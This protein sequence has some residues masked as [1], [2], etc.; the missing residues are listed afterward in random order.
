MLFL[1]YVEWTGLRVYDGMRHVCM[2]HHIC[3]MLHCTYLLPDQA[4]FLADGMQLELA[5]SLVLS[6]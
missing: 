2:L 1:M 5:R 6:S 3:V 4:V